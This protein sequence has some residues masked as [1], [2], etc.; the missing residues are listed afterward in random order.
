MR[1]VRWWRSIV[2]W[3]LTSRSTRRKSASPPIR[4][5]PT[6]P[7]AARRRPC[8]WLFSAVRSIRRTSATWP[9][10]LPP[11]R[12]FGWIRCS[13][14]PPD[15]SPLKPGEDRRRV[16][17]SPDDGGPGVRG[18]RALR[19]LESG[20]TAPRWLAQLHR[21]HAWPAGGAAA[22]G[23][24]LSARRRGQLSYAG[25]LAR[26]AAGCLRWPSGSS[27]AGPASRL[28]TPRACPSRRPSG[29]VSTFWIASMKRF[30]RLPCGRGWKMARRAPD[31]CRRGSKPISTRTA[32]TGLRGIDAAGRCAGPALL[33]QS[34]LTALSYP[35]RSS[36]PSTQ[37]YQ[38]LLAAA[39]AC[40]DKKAEDIRILALDPS[41]SGLTDYF[42]ICNGTNDRQNVAITDESRDP[43]QARLRHLPQLGRRPA[44]GR[45]GADGLCRLHRARLLGRKTRLLRVGAPAQIRT[46]PSASPN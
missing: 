43:P 5:R 37:S 3:R 21:A 9:W 2:R 20:R 25:R 11:R 46:P 34:R 36:M 4:R 40:E 41:E 14:R 38:L 42:L 45:V 23:R 35:F 27:S 16:C 26:A 8:V 10:R 28:K 19:G 17:R 6:P 39:A 29:S 33:R 7:A 44:P 32:C 31:C 22:G 24:A 1:W 13:S 18:R 12:S 15:A 30:Q